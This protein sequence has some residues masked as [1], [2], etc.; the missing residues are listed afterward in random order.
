MRKVPLEHLGGIDHAPEVIRLDPVEKLLKTEDVLQLAGAFYGSSRHD[1]SE[2]DD[3][4]NREDS[5][6]DSSAQWEVEGL[7]ALSKEPQ[8]HQQ[9]HHRCDTAA[10]VGAP[11]LVRAMVVE[12]ELDEPVEYAFLDA[13]HVLVELV[14]QVV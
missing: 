10:N 3:G 9:E 4:K 5:R 11:D 13:R 2:P 8:S 7:E 12:P 14:L 6:D 1:H